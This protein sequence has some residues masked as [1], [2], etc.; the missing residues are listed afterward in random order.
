VRPPSS[1]VVASGVALDFGP[2]QFGRVN[3]TRFQ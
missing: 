1:A 3:A 2:C